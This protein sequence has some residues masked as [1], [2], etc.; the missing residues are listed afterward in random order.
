MMSN[1]PAKGWEK[2]VNV[3]ADTRA[4]NKGDGW[5]VVQGKRLRASGKKRDDK[6]IKTMM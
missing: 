3:T 1:T 4:P 6:T 5:T 2:C